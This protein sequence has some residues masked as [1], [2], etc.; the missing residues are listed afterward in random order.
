MTDSEKQLQDLLDRLRRRV[1]TAPPLSFTAKQAAE[2]LAYFEH[3][4]CVLSTAQKV[5]ALTATL[6]DFQ[7]GLQVT[8]AVLRHPG[9][10]AS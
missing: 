5:A 8:D 1:A 6:R 4:D 3:P 10:R 7:R 9:D 2:Q